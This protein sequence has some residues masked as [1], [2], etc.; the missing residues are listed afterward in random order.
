MKLILTILFLIPF[1]I[2]AQ[3]KEGDTIFIRPHTDICGWAGF[4]DTAH[5]VKNGIKY[6]FKGNGANRPVVYS[7]R[8][9][10]EFWRKEGSKII[11]KK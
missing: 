3:Y 11:N 6:D 8:K 7:I 2:N 5:V 10:L 9:A 4:I 1:S